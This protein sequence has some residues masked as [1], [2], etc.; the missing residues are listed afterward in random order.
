MAHCIIL[1]R[2]KPKAIGDQRALRRISREI[3]QRI[4]K[5]LPQAHWLDTYALGPEAGWDFLDVFEVSAPEHADRL[6]AIIRETTGADTECWPAEPGAQ[7]DHPD[8]LHP[9]S[10]EEP[11]RDTVLEASMESMPASDAPASGGSTGHRT[12]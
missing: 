12:A 6:A 3:G 2:M 11:G 7:H 1:T 9:H 10:E 5:E 8:L 4:R